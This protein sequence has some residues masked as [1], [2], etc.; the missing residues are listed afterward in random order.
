MAIKQLIHKTTDQA[1]ASGGVDGSGQAVHF[2]NSSWATDAD[3]T[4]GT[5]R[6]KLVNPYNV[7]TAIN[8]TDPGD[9]SSGSAGDGL[10]LVADGSGGF[11]YGRG[12]NVQTVTDAGATLALNPNLYS[13]VIAT[14]TQ[15]CAVSISALTLG[16]DQH[17]LTFLATQ[18]GTGGWTPTFAANVYYNANT[19]PTLTTT[20]STSTLYGLTTLDGGTTWVCAMIATG[21]TLP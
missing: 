3:M 19:A 5:E 10:P 11:E 2:S 8:A 1:N 6:E 16:G 15:D 7:A 9:L 17:T 14:L 13:G 4:T 12:G 20:L 18:D 21:V